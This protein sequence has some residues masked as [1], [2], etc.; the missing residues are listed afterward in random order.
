M[1]FFYDPGNNWV[2]VIAHSYKKQSKDLPPREKQVALDRMA[3]FVKAKKER[4]V[5]YGVV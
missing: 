3:E 2:V 4:K 5:T 1:L